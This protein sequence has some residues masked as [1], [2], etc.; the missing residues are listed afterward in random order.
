MTDPTANTETA[1][2]LILTTGETRIDVPLVVFA[3]DAVPSLVDIT[4]SLIPE[5]FQANPEGVDLVPLTLEIETDAL[6]LLNQNIQSAGVQQIVVTNDPNLILDMHDGNSDFLEIGS[7]MGFAI[8]NG[9]PSAVIFVNYDSASS[10]AVEVADPNNPGD[11]DYMRPSLEAILAH[12]IGHLISPISMAYLAS[13]YNF[14]MDV[15][16][17]PEPTPFASSYNSIMGM[18]RYDIVNEAEREAMTFEALVMEFLFGEPV[19]ANHN[20]CIASDEITSP[21]SHSVGFDM[22]VFENYQEVCAQQPFGF[23]HSVP[24]LP[25]IGR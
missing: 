23:S 5:I 1:P 14:S 11:I 4:Q 2:D 22:V 20:D 3:T 15:P 21:L 16:P 9:V 25:A 24:Y 12:E 7:F 13:L 19:R 6:A 10:I 17:T 18:Q 8:V